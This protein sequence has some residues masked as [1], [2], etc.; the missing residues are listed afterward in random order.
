MREEETKNHVQESEEMKDEQSEELKQIMLENR[1]ASFLYDL[2][3]FHLPAGIVEKV[4][5]ENEKHWLSG[6]RG[7]RCVDNPHTVHHAFD[8]AKRIAT[9]SNTKSEV[10][11][12]GECRG[13]IE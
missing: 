11:R 7:V 10:L 4:L 9:G 2:I 8:M 13:R 1:I 5:K 12:D 3:S 6:A